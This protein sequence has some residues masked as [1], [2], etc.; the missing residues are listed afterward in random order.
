MHSSSLKRA[1]IGALA[2][3][4][5]TF[6][7]V[8]LFAGVELTRSTFQSVPQHRIVFNQQNSHEG[9]GTQRNLSHAEEVASGC[10]SG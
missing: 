9:D 5:A 7:P 8:Y 2:L 10:V 3:A 4:T 1:V 6:P